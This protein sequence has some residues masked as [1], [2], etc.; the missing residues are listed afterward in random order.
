VTIQMNGGGKHFNR[1]NA[2]VIYNNNKNRTTKFASY[3]AE[4]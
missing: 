4:L 1:F 2:Q 3:F